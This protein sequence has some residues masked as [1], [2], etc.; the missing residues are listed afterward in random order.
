MGEPGPAEAG[1]VDDLLWAPPVLALADG[2]LN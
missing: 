2:R 1:V